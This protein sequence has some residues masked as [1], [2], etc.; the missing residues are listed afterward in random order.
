MNAVAERLVYTIPEAAETL[1]IS[2]R[3]FRRH[4]LP[5]IKVLRVQGSVRI[6]VAEL[7][8]WVEQ[9]A[10]LSVHTL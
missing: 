5:N 3:S 8:T 2:E 9:N 7:S 6:P 4:V 1:A 10:T